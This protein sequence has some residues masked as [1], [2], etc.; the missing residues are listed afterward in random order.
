MNVKWKKTLDVKFNAT[1]FDGL[2]QAGMTLRMWNT[3]N[4]IFRLE[5]IVQSKA[6]GTKILAIHTFGI[7]PRMSKV[8]SNALLLRDIGAW[9]VPAGTYPEIDI[10]FKEYP[11]R[12]IKMQ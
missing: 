8:Q 11:L 3:N 4:F 12:P 9:I 2:T 5:E 6:M 7:R 1:V 10:A